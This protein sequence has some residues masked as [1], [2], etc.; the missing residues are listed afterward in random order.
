M[1]HR[2]FQYEF[3]KGTISQR[4]SGALVSMGEGIATAYALS[5]LQDRGI[6]FVEPGERCYNGQI[7]GEHNKENDLEVNVQKAKHAS[8][9]RAAGSDKALRVAPAV[10]FSLEES[11]EYIREDELVEV[12]PA[13]IRMRKMALN[14]NE[15][16]KLSKTR[17]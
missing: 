3:F 4:Q 5:A 1:H 6:F 12:T 10:K 13:S 2:F 14:A 11:L 7:V 17:S 8:N 16:K 9:M 15:R